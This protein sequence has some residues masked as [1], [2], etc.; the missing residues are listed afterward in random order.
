M[1]MLKIMII[2]DE[3]N[4]FELMEHAI[5]KEFPDAVVDLCEN[6]DASLKRLEQTGRDIIIADYLLAGMSGLEFLQELKR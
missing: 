4:H 2:E 6:V 1:N 5:K 3:K